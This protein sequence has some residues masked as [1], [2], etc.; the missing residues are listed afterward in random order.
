MDYTALSNFITGRLTGGFPRRSGSIPILIFLHLFLGTVSFTATS[1]HLDRI[2]SLKS[3]LQKQSG[4]DEYATLLELTFAYVDKDNNQSLRFIDQANATAIALGDTAKIVKCGR[5]KGQLL[6]RLD[7]LDEAMAIF[8]KLLAVA[9]RNDLQKDYNLMLNSLALAYTDRGNYDKALEYHFQSLDIREREGNQDEI[10]ISLGNIGFVYYKLDDITKAIEYFERSLQLAKKSEDEPEPY[11]RLLI[12]LGHCYKTI[13]DYDKANDYFE[14]GLELCGNNCPFDLLI[15]GEYGLGATYIEQ[16]K[17]A[18]AEVHFN[19]SY[20]MAV[21]AD[22][23]RFQAENLIHLSKI[24]MSRNEYDSAEQRLERAEVLAQRSGYLE[25]LGRIYPEFVTLYKQRKDYERASHYQDRY[26]QLKD[27]LFSE[28]L[29]KKV[30]TAQAKIEERENIKT[31]ANKDE[32]LARQRTLNLAFVV[33]AVLA[34][35]LVFMLYRSNSARR[36]ANERL[37]NEVKAATKDLQA[38][39]QLLAE[40]N[41]ELDHFIYKT[42]HDIRGPLAT[43]KGLCNVA[44]ADVNDATALRYLNKLDFTASQLDTLL[45]RLQKINQINNA[46]TQA[47]AIDFEEIV[48]SVVLMERR[49]GFPKRLTIQRQIQQDI[50]YT[51]DIELV[52]LI[53]ENLIANAIKFYDASDRIDPFVKVTI[54]MEDAAVVIRVI[55]NGIGIGEVNPEELFHIFARASERS[56]S[57]GIGLYLSRRATQKLGGEIDLHSTPE[58]HTEVV[59]TLPIK[60]NAVLESTAK[61]GGQKTLVEH[62]DSAAISN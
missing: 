11:A 29:I 34:T 60:H 1:Q 21:Q 7:R 55:D 22:N 46:A 28:G 2:D 45:R 8:D 42:S 25:L 20:T 31:I 13:S 16:A 36:K 41:Q 43:L 54:G 50:V 23:K 44:L 49:K 32:E 38:A 37:D 14:S 62:Q 10:S 17:F 5:I 40:V 35:L 15:D 52:T 27:S 59:V 61:Q 51:S 30:A 12:N 9:K 57:G 48:N 19:Q 4:S 39:N 53:L 6:R 3:I 24:A 56:L 58:G 47:S 18:E 26:I 33:I